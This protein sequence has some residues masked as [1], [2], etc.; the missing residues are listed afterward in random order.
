MIC[1]INRYKNPSEELKSHLKNFMD[2]IELIKQN[3]IIV[4]FWLLDISFY[5]EELQER[6]Q[7]IA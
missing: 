1:D 3:G 7:I 4:D 2:K 5:K 6:R